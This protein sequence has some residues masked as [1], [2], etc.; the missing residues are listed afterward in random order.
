FPLVNWL[1][2]R[3]IQIRS[4]FLSPNGFV[5]GKFH[6]SLELQKHVTSVVATGSTTAHHLASVINCLSNVTCVD[7]VDGL[8]QISDLLPKLSSSSIESL[9]EIHG[10]NQWEFPLVQNL[11]KS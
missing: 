10:I 4:L 7:V 9:M 5:N 8:C 3:D 2:A 1:N 6:Y 11:C